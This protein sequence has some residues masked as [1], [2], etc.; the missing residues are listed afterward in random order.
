MSSLE[1]EEVKEF[2]RVLEEELCAVGTYEVE[3][4]WSTFKEALREAQKYLL[5]AT[6]SEEKVRVTNEVREVS[7]R[8]QEAW[9][10]W[11]KSPNSSNLEEY[12]ELKVLS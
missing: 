1:E 3:D 12:Q 2:K 5:P 6:E 10:R 11:V 8:K 9:M 4:A 7:K